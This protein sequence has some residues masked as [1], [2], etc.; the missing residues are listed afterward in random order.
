MTTQTTTVA[1][2]TKEEFQTGRI[3]TIVSGH[4]T[5]DTF[6]AF[7]APLLPLLIA[8]L[9]MSLTVAGSLQFFIQI[10][11]LLNPFI[12]YVADRVSVRYFIIFAPAITATIFSLLGL[13][14]SYSVLV[15][16]LF[17]GGISVAAFHAPAPAM[18]SRI[19]GNQIGKGM[20]YFMAG[21]ELGRTI[22]PLLGGLG[23]FNL[24]LW[25]GSIGSWCWA[26]S[27]ALFYFGGYATFQRGRRS[28][29]MCEP[30]CPL[31][32]NCLSRWR[33]LSFSEHLWP[34]LFRFTY[35]PL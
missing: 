34:F 2:S 19:S 32:N 25:K 20:S 8:K 22:G 27:P 21:G 1:Q 29:K 23:R 13:A 12:G 3:V 9:S 4:F 18:I 10:P 7:L 35:P 24:G 15:L 30:C 16:M 14:P 11:A 33:C 5:H 17:V 28:H 6:S 26:G 31:S